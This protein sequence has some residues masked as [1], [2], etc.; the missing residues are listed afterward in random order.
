MDVL[1]RKD[2][3]IQEIQV[4]MAS[5]KKDTLSKLAQKFEVELNKELDK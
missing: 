3:E 1:K 4:N 5:W 2:Q